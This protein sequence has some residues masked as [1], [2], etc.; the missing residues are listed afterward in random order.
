MKIFD[1]HCDTPYVNLQ[2]EPAVVN[3]TETDRFEEY[4]ACTAI[5]IGERAKNP[6]HL[7]KQMLVEANKL[8]FKHILTLE[9]FCF[10]DS[11]DTVDLLKKDGICAA[12]LTW[13]YNNR[14]AGGC[15][16]DGVLT[17]LGKM[18]I[19]RMNDYGIMLDLSHI[20]E[21]SFRYNP[22]AF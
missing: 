16:D 15:L 14:L 11:P 13:N 21:K 7:Y 19:R 9:G 6:L 12:T 8:D 10:A 17:S 4:V 18:V 5:W 3:K 1:L 22:K 20:N 2:G